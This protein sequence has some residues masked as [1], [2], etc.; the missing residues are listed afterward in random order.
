MT[1]VKVW[2]T[3]KK[4]CTCACGITSLYHEISDDSMELDAI[5]VPTSTQL[6]KVPASVWCMFPV[7]LHYDGPHPGIQ[8]TW[9]QNSSWT[10]LV[11]NNNMWVYEQISWSVF[12]F[13]I[14]AQ[15]SEI[16]TLFHGSLLNKHD[17]GWQNFFFSKH[18]KMNV[19]SGFRNVKHL[20]RIYKLISLLTHETQHA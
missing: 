4:L 2:Q 17:K 13:L 10:S 8:T 12:I 14:L 1:M 18:R 11:T 19:V 6:C 9:S 7:Q 16:S 20:M 5:I 3:D 15:V